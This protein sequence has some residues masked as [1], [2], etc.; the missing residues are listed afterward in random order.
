MKRYSVQTRENI[1]KRLWIFV[2]NMGK[3]IGKN[4]SK[5]LNCRYSEKRLDHAK[6]SAT[7]FFKTSSK[8]V[9]RNR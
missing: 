7:D 6:Q 4:V 8:R 5:S 9:I 3:N 1:F 2:F